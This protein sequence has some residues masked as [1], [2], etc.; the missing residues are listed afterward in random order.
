[1]SIRDKASKI[2]FGMLPGV[3]APETTDKVETRPKTAPGFL[4]AHAVNQKSDLL[5]E[6]ETLKEQVQ[7]LSAAASRVKELQEEAKVWENAK[8]TRL[9]DTALI[10][11]SRWA[12]RDPKHFETVQFQQLKLEIENSGGNVVPIKVRPVA[13][14]KYEIVYGHRRHEACRQLG[15]EVLALV[16][17]LDDVGLF[18]EMERENRNRDDLSPWEKGVWY[19][20]I[21]KRG[22]FPSHR[23]L[24]DAIGL[25][26]STVSR[27]ITIAEL[28]QQVVDA[29]ASPLD[30]Q[31]RWTA[32]LLNAW[33]TDKSGLLQRAEELK[34]K[35][36]RPNAAAVFS[37]LASPQAPKQDSHKKE[38]F[39]GGQ[40]IASLQIDKNGGGSLSFSK[41][42]LS[43]ARV[44]KLLKFLEDI[45]K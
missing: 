22:L 30:L 12:N 44:Q 17:N 28:P 38:V 35:N 34:L 21:L 33:T 24:A 42:V 7:D 14:G 29:F 37:F 4:M 3:A 6:N 45:A 5:R 41:G 39:V 1:M 16:D 19:Q 9:I 27:A 26:Q 23:K 32:P 31:Y 36:P 20:S 8:V 11:R 13:D 25:D 43:E 15:L 40:K 2:N 10:V 18:V